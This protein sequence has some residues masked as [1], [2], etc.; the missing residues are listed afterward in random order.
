MVRMTGTQNKGTLQ[1]LLIKGPPTESP[2]KNPPTNIRKQETE[3]AHPN[4]SQNTMTQNWPRR[5]NSEGDERS[6]EERRERRC[7][8]IDLVAP[9][10]E[11]STSQRLYLEK[12]R[13]T[14]VVLCVTI[15]R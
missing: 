9:P 1:R 5:M 15:E 14:V 8:E 3:S 6:P 11:G 2:P 10:V 12:G 7:G 4:T 13:S